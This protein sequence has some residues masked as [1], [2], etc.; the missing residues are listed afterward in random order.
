MPVANIRPLLTDEFEVVDSLL[1]SNNFRRSF[2]AYLLVID[3]DILRRRTEMIS[4]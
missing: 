1:Q 2:T 3:R 4:I